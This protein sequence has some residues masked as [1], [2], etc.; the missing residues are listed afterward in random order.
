MRLSIIIPVYNSEKILPFLVKA[1]FKNLKNKIPKYEIILVNDFS[2][3]K[4]WNKIVDLSKKYKFIKG[5]DHKQNYGQHTAIFTG[6]KY[7][8]GDNII[9]LDDDMQHDPIYLYEIYKKLNKGYDVC[10]VKYLNR[11]HSKIKIFFSWLNNIVSSYI[12]NKSSKV[13]TSSFK[14]FS[15]NI[16]NNIINASSKFIF[17]DYWIINNSKNLTTI[18]VKHKK[19]AIGVTN[20]NIRELFTLWS[21]MFFIVEVKKIS[22]RT[23]IIISFRFLFRTFFRKYVKLENN[24][25]ISINKTTF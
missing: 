17:L 8:K 23:F 12:M 2:R 1:I 15:K 10:Y 20:Y 18:E 25:K 14:G 21:K 19:R 11:Q 5:I 9:C 22:L 3:D 7:S 4:S 16:K 24:I 6:L 13:Y